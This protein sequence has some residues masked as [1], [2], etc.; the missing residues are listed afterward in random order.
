MFRT[1]CASA[2][3]AACFF[4]LQC[5]GTA[6]K[7]MPEYNHM[8]V[9][10]SRLAIVFPKE[11]LT[12]H[13]PDDIV[14]DLGEGESKQVFCDFFTARLRE[15]ALKDGTFAGIDV[16][17]G[18]DTSGFTTIT[19]SLSA[20]KTASVKVPGRTPFMSDS[21]AY[22]LILDGIDVSREKKAGTTVVVLGT[23]GIPIRKTTG[24]CDRITLKGS[25]VLWDNLAGKAAALGQI[26]EKSDVVFSNTKNALMSGIK[27]ISSEIFI[28]RPFGKQ[29]SPPMEK[30]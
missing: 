22:L 13:N 5:A 28:N 29:S 6:V 18:F 24:D 30:R 4:V 26:N 12:L 14:G 7:V 25:F 16:V 17:S 20:D 23:S 27:D 1:V 8:Q 21:L 9:G 15:F 19:H 3:A 2:A 11:W 10:K